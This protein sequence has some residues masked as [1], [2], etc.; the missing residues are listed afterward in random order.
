MAAGLTGAYAETIP[1]FEVLTLVV[2]C[3]GVLLGVRDGMLTGAIT[4]LVYSLLN[5]YGAAPPLITLSQ[6]VGEAAAGGAGGV[7]ASA[8]LAGFQSAPR[9]AVMA[10]AAVILTLFLALQA[11]SLL[12]VLRYRRTTVAARHR[13]RTDLLWTCI[14][15]VIVLFLA[16]R[17]WVA[18]FGLA[19]PE[20]AAAVTK[21]EPDA[22]AR[23]LAR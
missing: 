9:A 11:R 21:A 5:P 19:Q 22:T 10:T 3:S 23:V 20:I 12:V 8:G 1:N 17:S 6:V 18:V 13:R 2:F 7:L 14:P 16:A 15:V 4:M